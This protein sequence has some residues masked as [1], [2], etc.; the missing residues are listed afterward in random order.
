MQEEHALVA[1]RAQQECSQQAPAEVRVCS[2]DRLC[3][4]LCCVRCAFRIRPF[5]KL[6]QSR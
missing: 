2:R 4:R 3:A 6:R 5:R 1:A